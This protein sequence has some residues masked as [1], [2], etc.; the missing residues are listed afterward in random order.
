VTGKPWRIIDDRL[1]LRVRL[2]PRASR[3]AV[4]GVGETPFGPALEVRVRAVADK[5]EANA[6][7][8]ELISETLKVPRRS[9]A[10]TGGFKSRVKTLTIAGEA[11]LLAAQLKTRFD[12]PG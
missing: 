11:R 5:G 1:V 10:V 6:A 3:D 8:E 4:E 2:T 9:V 7:L 12:A